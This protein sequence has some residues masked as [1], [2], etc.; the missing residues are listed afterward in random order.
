MV[1]LDNILPCS[2]L[3]TINS[4][5]IRPHLDYGDVIYDQPENGG[6]RGISQEK[7]YQKI[8]LESLKSRIIKTQ[9]LLYLFSLIPRKLNSLRHSNTYSV[10][11]CRNNY[12]KNSSMPYVLRERNRLST[13]IR[14]STSCQQ[15]RKLILFFIKPAY[16]LIFSI[17][18]LVLVKLLVRSR[19]GLNH[20][21]EHKFKHDF[22]DS[23]NPLC[24]S[25]LKPET[26]IHYHLCMCNFSSTRLL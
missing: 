2:A 9:K 19:L 24:S 16:S 15:F 1:K 3:L 10:M 4:S 7:L 18:H 23:L 13:E 12:F 11:R 6:E 25:S 20:L 14:N 22:H 17:D 21:R 26:I 8:C 5:F